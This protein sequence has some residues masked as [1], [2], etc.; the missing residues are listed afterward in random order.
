MKYGCA[1]CMLVGAVLGVTAVVLIPNPIPQAEYRSEVESIATSYNIFNQ[2]CP[3]T[4]ELSFIREVY[5]S[6]ITKVSKRLWIK[7]NF[8]RIFMNRCIELERL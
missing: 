2:T 6:R 8:D 5:T 3:N 4:R 1:K 7:D